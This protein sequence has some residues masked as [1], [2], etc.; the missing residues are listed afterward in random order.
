MGKMASAYQKRLKKQQRARAKAGVTMSNDPRRK[1]SSSGSRSSKRSS[2][3]RS[4]SKSKSSPSK[5]TIVVYDASGKVTQSNDPSKPVGSVD[6]TK[7]RE[8]S[9]SKSPDYTGKSVVY[10]RKGNTITEKVFS[11]GGKV[12]T[13]VLDTNQT[14]S[15]LA[16][17]TTMIRK[18]QES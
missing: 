6:T 18:A 5:K 11:K 7:V 4:S 10:E 14:T 13:R 8:S 16:K 2:S 9:L 17:Q 12:S 1:S 3:K 15:Q